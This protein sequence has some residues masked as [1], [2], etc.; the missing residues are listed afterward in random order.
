MPKF[1]VHVYDRIVVKLSKVFEADDADAATEIA[2][3]EE[4]SSAN[5][6]DEEYDSRRY[7][8]HIDWVEEV[9]E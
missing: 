3:S 5:G 6:W 8:Q 2:E 4:Y 9:I 1:K 7:D